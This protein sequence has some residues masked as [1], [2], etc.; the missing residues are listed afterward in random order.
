MTTTTTRA[1]P[2]AITALGDEQE[3][4]ETGEG[5]VE[6]VGMGRRLHGH[7]PRSRS[8]A[9]GLAASRST[10]HRVGAQVACSSGAGAVTASSSPA[11]YSSA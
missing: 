9:R 3:V 1:N 10:G 6:L 4:G 2:T 8:R 5:A 7:E 11:G